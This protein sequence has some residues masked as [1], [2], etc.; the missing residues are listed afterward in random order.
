MLFESEGLQ[1]ALGDA[2]TRDRLHGRERTSEEA[3]YLAAVNK[4][5][6]LGPKEKQRCI[7]SAKERFG[8]MLR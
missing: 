5:E 1:P 4:C 8:E 3:D 2:R 7:E 6:G